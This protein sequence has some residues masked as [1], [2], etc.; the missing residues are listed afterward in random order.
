MK[1]TYH[2]PT[3]QYGFVEV[4]M[5]HSNTRVNDFESYEDIKSVVSHQSG[6]GLE[7]KEFN[8][9]LDRYVT[10]GTGETEVYLR[11]SKEQQAVIQEL[12]K[13]FKRIEAKNK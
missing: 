7:P 11:M 2:I 5:D 9:C 6:L 1:I 10:D 13:S 3:E 12:K 4:E 8:D